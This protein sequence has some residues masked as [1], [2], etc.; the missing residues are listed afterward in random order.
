MLELLLLLH[1]LLDTL[2][3]LLMLLLVRSCGL[4]GEN[5]LLQL[6]QLRH[7]LLKGGQLLLVG[8]GVL[9]EGG[10]GLL[11]LLLELALLK[12]LLLQLLIELLQ[13]LELGQLLGVLLKSG[14]Q[15]RLLSPFSVDLAAGLG[16]GPL[17]GR[18]GGQAPPTRG[19]GQVRHILQHLTQT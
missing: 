17:T 7:V 6:L 9:L 11:V 16:L 15:L 8:D 13:L 5:G 1:D 18:D 3:E 12:H 14:L 19:Q 2:L 10:E 4:L